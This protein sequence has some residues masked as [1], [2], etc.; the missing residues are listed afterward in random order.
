MGDILDLQ[1]IDRDAEYPPMNVMGLII[2]GSYVQSIYWISD[3]ME[4]P[5]GPRPRDIAPISAHFDSTY[6]TPVNEASWPVD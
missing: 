1:K 4:F 3:I 6:R 2:I 5:K